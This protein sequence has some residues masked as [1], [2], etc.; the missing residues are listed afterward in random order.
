M[1]PLCH[2]EYYSNNLLFLLMFF[3]IFNGVVNDS[4]EHNLLFCHALSE[5]QVKNMQSMHPGIP[6]ISA[7]GYSDFLYRVILY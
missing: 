7:A 4:N 5:K 6:W 2:R 1:Q 3:S